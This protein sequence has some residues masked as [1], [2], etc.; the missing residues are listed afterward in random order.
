MLSQF[1]QREQVR[2]EI[3]RCVQASYRNA[4]V[5]LF[6]SSSFML[7][8]EDSDIDVCF[9]SGSPKAA[10]QA[11]YPTFKIIFPGVEY[12]DSAKVPILRYG[13]YRFSSSCLVLFSR[14]C[15]S[16]LSLMNFRYA[17][18]KCYL[19]RYN[20][21]YRF[22]LSA[23]ASGHQKTLLLKSYMHTYP[24]LLPLLLVVA[25]WGRATNI[26]G[27]GVGPIMNLFGLVWMF[28]DYCLQENVIKMVCCYAPIDTV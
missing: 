22:D 12:L 27:H 4:D 17:L 15:R 2:K 16:S 19:S 25:N 10:L 23:D 14:T 6:G 18:L 3:E 11:V 7:F 1:T 9:H 20:G 5:F 8:A 13:G 21:E 28:L 24:F 26:V